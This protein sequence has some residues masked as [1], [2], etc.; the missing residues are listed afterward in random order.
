MSSKPT[1]YKAV[2]DIPDI[3]KRAAMMSRAI[4]WFQANPDARKHYLNTYPNEREVVF[5]FDDRTT[6]LTFKLSVG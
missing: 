4:E 5:T 1:L 2:F 3:F 6:A